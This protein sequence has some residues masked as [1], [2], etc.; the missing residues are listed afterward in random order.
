MSP[1]QSALAQSNT[2]AAPGRSGRSHPR[3]SKFPLTF[4]AARPPYLPWD[5]AHGQRIVRG[6]VKYDSSGIR[7]A[8]LDGARRR[9]SRLRIEST[10][11]QAIARPASGGR[12]HRCRAN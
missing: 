4:N 10:G 1:S 7:R 3:D 12:D 5:A 11:G 9:T 2:T 6:T 8:L